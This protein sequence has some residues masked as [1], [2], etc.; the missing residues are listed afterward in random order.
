MKYL[1]KAFVA[2][3]MGMPIP[4]NFFYLA[5]VGL[6]GAF[7]SPGFLVLGLG[8][9]IAYLW[10]LSQNKRFRRAVD[11][12]EQ[13]QDP[14]QARYQAMLLQLTPDQQQR[15]R[16]I[17]SRGRE[18]FATL[19]ATPLLRSH[20]ES[21]EQLIWLHLKLLLA[22]QAILGVVGT[23]RR[24]AAKLD[25]QEADIEKRLQREDLSPELRRSLEQQKSVIDQ[26]QEAHLSAGRRL[27]HVDAELD[28]IEQQ[29]ALIREQAL[30]SSNED[31]IGSS[32]DALTASFNETQRWLS[33]Q[34]D[35]LDSLDMM[36]GS[37][38][39]ASVLREGG[40]T[41]ATRAAQTQ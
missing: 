33:G 32:L 17:E 2:R 10:M 9:E 12:G 8:G 22:R 19:D 16:D 37:A 1:W 5:A 18:I 25:A 28:R 26:R 38:L 24:D 30:L 40:R 20:I 21:L 27:E 15:Q 31:Q 35:L 34:R 14:A 36:T 13:S 4:P 11:V 7:A 39:P 3:P 6:L 29:I 41:P 23:A